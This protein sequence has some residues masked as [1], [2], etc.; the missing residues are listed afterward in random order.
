VFALFLDI[1]TWFVGNLMH[2]KI[3]KEIG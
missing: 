2:F 1:G 3:V